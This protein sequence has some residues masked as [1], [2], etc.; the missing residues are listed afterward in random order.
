MYSM[1]PQTK[2]QTGFE[3][4]PIFSF[5]FLLQKS[6]EGRPIWFVCSGMG[7]QWVGMCRRMMEF[8]LFRSSIM[9]SD[10]ILKTVGFNLQEMLL[11]A[12]EKTF[13]NPTNSFTGI[14]ATQV[15]AVWVGWVVSVTVAAGFPHGRQPEFPRGEIPLGPYS[16]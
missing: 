12:D 7:A 8:P 6:E 4:F 11:T 13:D 9:K 5:I 15:C 10:A 3:F 1:V 14:I 2:Y 16:C